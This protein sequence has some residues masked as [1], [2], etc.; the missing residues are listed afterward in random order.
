[1]KQNSCTLFLTLFLIISLPFISRSQVVD[2]TRLV[3]FE[4]AITKGEA[5]LQAKDYAHAKAEYQKAL[6]IDPQAKYPKD[7][8]AQIRKVYTDPKDEVDFNNAVAKG[9]QYMNSGYYEEAKKDYT[10]ALV[11]KPDD[12]LIKE[13]ITAADKAFTEKNSK[14]KEF[15]VIVADAD[16]LYAD[17]NFNDALLKYQQAELLN[18]S[19]IE[20]RNKIA[21]IQNKLAVEKGIEEKYNSELSVADEAYMNRDFTLAKKK[22]EEASKIKPSETY[23]KS[24]LDRVKE[25]IAKQAQDNINNENQ[26]VERYNNAITTGEQLIKDDRLNEALQSFTEASS[27]KPDEKYPQEKIEQINNILNKRKEVE[28]E[29]LATLKL[30]EQK[31]QDSINSA[32][33]AQRIAEEVRKSDELKKEADKQNELESQRL[34]ELKDEEEKQNESDAQKQAILKQEE[35]RIS[36][37]NDQK[38]KEE[39]EQDSLNAV[40]AVV[41]AEEAKLAEAKIRETEEKRELELAMAT[42]TDKA[43]Y[44]AVEAGNNLYTLQDLPSALK[45]YEKASGLKPAEKYPKDRIIY[46]N[47]ILLERLKN[48][49]ESYNKY[50]AAGD[51]AFQSNVFDKALEEFQKAV[52]ARPEEKYPSMMIDRIKKLMEDNALIQLSTDA[53]MLIDAQ[54]KR[55]NFKPVDMKLR[56][57]NYLLIKAK[58]TSEKAPKVFINYGKDD[59]KSGGFVLKGI[60]SDESSDYLL[61]ISIQDK[62]YRVDNNWISL[63]PE[64]GDIEITSIQISQGDIQTLK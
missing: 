20:T 31:K 18:P 41:R 50:I 24:M 14:L 17:K 28:D 30:S 56:K 27:I 40:Q 51:L 37:L 32:N 12:K 36:I 38:L 7:K 49:L 52:E 48:N 21:D 29:Q 42:E 55:F 54:E 33:E 22:Y 6:S 47:N 64:G 62:W 46:I 63:Y 61:R 10:S 34:A 9:D 43:Y 58:K 15:E 59:A 60:E 45:M 4:D 57:N 8:L 11:I 2:K 13:K 1:M 3:E 26:L 23:P 19:D 16:K 5:F 35:E 25:S 39:R 53:T 44:E